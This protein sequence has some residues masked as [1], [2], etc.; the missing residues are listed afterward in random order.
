MSALIN[1]AT[2][3]ISVNERSYLSHD[4]IQFVQKESVLLTM[5]MWAL[6]SG[7]E[8][9]LLNKWNL[10]NDFLYVDMKQANIINEFLNTKQRQYTQKDHTFNK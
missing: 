1:G 2:A 10:D 8:R 3:H 4:G 9:T 5:N 7:D 6:T